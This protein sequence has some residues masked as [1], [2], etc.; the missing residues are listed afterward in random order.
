[1]GVAKY[2]LLD[3]DGVIN[4]RI[5]NGYVT[6]PEQFE[7]LPRA[8]DALRLLAEYGYKV[9]VV[10]N[11][12]CVGK[13]LIS[14]EELEEITRRFVAEVEKHGGRIGGVYYCPHRKE[15]ECECRKPRPGLL[16]R[17]QREHHFVFA[18]TFVVGDSLSD[19]RA[20]RQAGCPVILVVAAPDPSGPPKGVEAPQATVADLYAAAQFILRRGSSVAAE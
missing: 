9:M 20:A 4:R 8:L 12:A 11:Q 17:A 1:V 2:V 7:F 5:A 18:E 3:R 10:S 6:S 14:A 19:L 13:G 15:D 16:I